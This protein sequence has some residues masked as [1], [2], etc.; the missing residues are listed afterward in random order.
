M[1][2]IKKEGR[3]SVL[4]MARKNWVVENKEKEVGA[5]REFE[6]EEV[7]TTRNPN[8]TIRL[9]SSSGGVG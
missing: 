3:N 6:R 2:F 8:H 5:I 4:M 9:D 7:R 1:G